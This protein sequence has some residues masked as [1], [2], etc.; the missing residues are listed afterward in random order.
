MD[1]NQTPSPE[2][3]INHDY[4]GVSPHRQMSADS[5]GAQFSSFEALDSLEDSLDETS[6]LTAPRQILSEGELLELSNRLNDL[7]SQI[8]ESPVAT[9][10]YFI[11]D[12]LKEGG[13]YVSITGSIRHLDESTGTLYLTDGSPILLEY[14]LNIMQPSRS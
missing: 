4:R 3:L 11:P 13:R 12:P 5:R 6:R 7:L 2:F 9:F 8:P 10:T 14:I 1:D